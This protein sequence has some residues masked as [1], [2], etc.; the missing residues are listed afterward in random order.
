MHSP[1]QENA[2]APLKILVSGTTG[3]VGGA[4]RAFLL[5]HGHH[6]I[7]LVRGDKRKAEDTVVWN[8]MKGKVPL[9]DLEGFDAVIHLAGKNITSRKWNEK[10]KKEIFQSRCRDTWLLAEG[11][12][13]LKSPPKTFICASAVGIYGNRGDETL[14]EKSAPGK[15]FL[16][17]TCVQWERAA[18]RVEERGVR[19]VSTRFGVILSP[20]GGMVARM[21]PIFRMGL[22]AIV[23]SGKQYMPWVA[24]EDVLGSIYHC[25]MTEKIKGGVNVVS[26]GL[27]TNETFSRKL[28]K[29]LHRPLFLRLNASLLRFV[30]GE[31]ADE[32]LLASTKCLPKILEESGYIFCYPTLSSCFSKS[33]GL[34]S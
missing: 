15:G 3:L 16:A 10:V 13:R 33:S 11:L 17:D 23:G 21:L 30:M 4:M 27:E 22:G 18:S 12:S 1:T 31:M 14:T 34:L 6:V 28:A 5:S 19:R 24:L 32:L 9:S 20:K 7:Q 25:L 26:P 29:G 8:P 2:L